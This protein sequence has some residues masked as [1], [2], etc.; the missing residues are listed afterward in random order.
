M[1]SQDEPG[2]I[3]K[4]PEQLDIDFALEVAR[5]GIWELDP[6][7]NYVLWDDRCRGL[8]GISEG[9]S[10][11][12][13]QALKH[14]HPDDVGR[15]KIAVARAIEPASDGFYDETYRTI[16]ADDGKLRWARFYG[17][18]YFS[19]EGDV[20]RFAGVAHE[21]TE[22]KVAE[23]REDAVRDLAERQQRVLETI[24]SS[25]PDLMYVFDLNYRFTYANQALLAMWGAKWENS[26][27]KSLLEIGYEPWH[28]EMHER[29]IDQVIATRKPIR[30]QVSFPHA[31]LG[32][33]IYD[34]V[35]SPVINQLGG[36]EAIAGTT[37][38]VT[39]LI[40]A[41]Q[42]LEENQAALHTAIEV[43]EL[44]TWAFDIAS[45]VC[46]FSQ[47]VADWFGLTTT[48]VDL[49]SLLACIA[50]SDRAL[51]RERFLGKHQLQQGKHYDQ[52]FT[53]INAQDM[54]HRIIH[55]MGV[56]Y[57]NTEGKAVKIQGS[58]QDITAERSM[59]LHLE[60]QVHQRTRE[61]ERANES[62]VR[63]NDNLQNFA[64][65][66]SH[67]LQEPLR[68]IQQF[69]HLLVSRQTTF[70]E[71]ELSY[72]QR[73][74]SAAE[75]MS[76][77]I[78][79]LLSFA[80]VSMHRPL[81]GPVDLNTIIETV[82]STLEVAISES[83]A[84]IQVEHLP[85][86]LGSASQLERLFQNLIGNAVKFRR[87]SIVPEIKIKVQT[88]EP[89]DWP[90]FPLPS[91]PVV[92]CYRIDVSDNGIGFDEKYLDRIFQVFQRLHG[93]SEFSGTGIGLAICE[94]VVANHGGAIT[95]SSTL[96]EGSTFSVFFPIA[97]AGN[98][99]NG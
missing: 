87:P 20:Y 33:R 62:L 96:N 84:V 45:K 95:A 3:K 7:S 17:R 52:T 39:D 91:E 13:E 76:A 15:V 63:S 75:R 16:G 56:V 60:Q 18:A 89:G 2:S 46:T 97:E 11:S 79:D 42:A 21:V 14:I 57:V 70:S 77:L 73:M 69:G 90:G 38:D 49:E 40:I 47:R 8:F 10:L 85:E 35:F 5:L 74:R 37:R 24:S 66:A 92:P 22:Q 68:K 30:G 26:V 99:P 27:G 50:D 44:G 43:A 80:K 36:V 4:L 32:R 98:L 34:Y 88:Y 94:R 41:R 78:D 29:E 31:S 81:S 82:I 23:Q 71:N 61:L 86:I 48:A 55:A 51:V 58:A 59:T 93:K 12:Y 65:V 1:S 64:Y 28:A 54:Q 19:I 25:T 72:V 83:N 9:N 67:D 6:K 53:V